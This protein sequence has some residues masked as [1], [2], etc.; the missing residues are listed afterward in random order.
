MGTLTRRIIE[1]MR[2][3]DPEVLRDLW[4]VSDLLRKGWQP[5][6]HSGFAD[7]DAEA[8]SS[9]EAA[10]LREVLLDSLHRQ[11]QADKQ[12]RLLFTLAGGGDQSVKER[13]LHE[14]HLALELTRAAAGN[15]WTA[16]IELDHLGEDVFPRSLT[17]RGIDQVADNIEAATNYLRKRGIL[18][19]L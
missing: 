11:T 12:R 6:Y 5:D 2:R 13:L 8:V 1:G 10:E 4:V 9:E 16:L 15:L 19:P 18:V 7:L 17:S 14:V 3:D